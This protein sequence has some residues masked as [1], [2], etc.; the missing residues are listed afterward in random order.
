MNLELY[1]C[2]DECIDIC[3][4]LI[5]KTLEDEEQFN[6]GVQGQLLDSYMKA[7]DTS[8]EVLKKMREA[9]YILLQE[10]VNSAQI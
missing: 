2:L 8:M 7:S 10:E 6:Q 5:D 4:A 3:N 9:M 1:K